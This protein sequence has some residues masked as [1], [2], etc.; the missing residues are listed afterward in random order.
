LSLEDDGGLS[1][2]GAHGDDVITL[3]VDQTDI[4][5]THGMRFPGLRDRVVQGCGLKA[6]GLTAPVCRENIA[7][8]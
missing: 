7:K 6:I 8:L 1:E 4:R 5:M 2:I 3:K